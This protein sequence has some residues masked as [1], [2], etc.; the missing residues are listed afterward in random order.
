MAKKCKQIRDARATSSPGRISL[1]LEVEKA[2][3]EEAVARSRCCRCRR[4]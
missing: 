2:P 1:A 4:C 3:W